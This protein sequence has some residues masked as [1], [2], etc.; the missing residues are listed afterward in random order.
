MRLI[1]DS[2]VPKPVEE[3]DIFVVVSETGGPSPRSV[4]HAG[5]V[6]AKLLHLTAVELDSSIT[7][8]DMDWKHI[9]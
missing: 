8:Q 6:E 3:D 7:I 9:T 1:A 2:V 4:G 5:G